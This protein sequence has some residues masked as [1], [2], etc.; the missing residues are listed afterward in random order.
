MGRKIKCAGLVEEMEKEKFQLNWYAFLIAFAIG[1][2]YIY[3]S[4]PTP[5]VVIKYPSPF[6]AGKIV[7]QGDEEDTCYKYSAEK[8]ECPK[9][10]TKIV[11]QPVSAA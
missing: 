4:V 10:A 2:A 9:D 6:N 3:F 11:P 8:I 5:K 7:Y 1:I